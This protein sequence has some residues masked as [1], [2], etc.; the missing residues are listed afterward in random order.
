MNGIKEVGFVDISNVFA[1]KEKVDHMGRIANFNF[2]RAENAI[3]TLSL[4][5]GIALGFGI[6]SYNEV[7]KLKLQVKELKETAG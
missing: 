4:S 1:T 3:V 7:K 2:K 6:V 5:V